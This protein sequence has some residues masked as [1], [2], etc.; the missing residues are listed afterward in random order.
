LLIIIKSSDF[1]AI[2]KNSKKIL[3]NIKFNPQLDFHMKNILTSRIDYLN[4]KDGKIVRNTQA[5]RATRSTV[6][7]LYIYINLDFHSAK[8]WENETEK[9]I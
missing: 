7:K 5:I 9:N 6:A 2:L 4:F 1:L 8:K 3:K